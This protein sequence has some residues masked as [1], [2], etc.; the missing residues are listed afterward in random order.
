MSQSGMIFR[1][2]AGKALPTA[3]LELVIKNNPRAWG[4]CFVDDDGVPQ[5][6][7]GENPTVDLIEATV[8]EYPDKDLTFY[9]GNT[10]G[11]LNLDDVSPHVVLGTSDAP[12]IVG[13]VSGDFNSY[14][15]KESS[16][17]SEFFFTHEYLIP[18]L[19][20]LLE[21]MED[22]GKVWA[23]L[24]KPIMKKKM[25][26]EAT[27]SATI[28]LVAGNG[29]ALTFHQ[30][31]DS[32][33]YEWG[34][35]S[36]NYGYALAPKEEVSDKPKGMFS[37]PSTKPTSRSTVR[38]PA[39]QATTSQSAA[40]TST[41]PTAKATGGEALQNYSV[42]KET[43]PGHLSRKDKK[44][45]IK[46]RIG[47][48]PKG[49]D[50]KGFSFEVYVGP[51]GKTLMHS[52]VKTLGLKAMGLP[53][54]NNPEWEKDETPDTVQPEHAKP[55]ETTPG[56]VTT[57]LLPILSPA[58]REYF[59]KYKDSDAVKKQIAENGEAVQDPKAIQALEEK[60]SSFPVQLGLKSWAD[61]PKFTHAHRFEIAKTRPDIAAAA[62]THLTNLCEKSG[63]FK[64]NTV[65]EQQKQELAAE[66][67]K[68]EVKG[69]FGK[70]STKPKRSAA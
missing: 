3:F 5:I 31:D 35:T 42:R 44:G 16:H 7:K 69:M 23:H 27:S 59:H 38:E 26:L 30:G 6:A 24:N 61:V 58:A 15:K 19:Q 64:D 46:A 56:Q 51:D 68:P 29:E 50:Q 49:W 63:L 9:V 18:E 66:E 47:Y 8:E 36:H 41:K 33:E 55:A 20:A 70:P 25:L 57:D 22:P 54:L 13:F 45:Y 62:W 4:C 14:A 32:A 43:I 40:P 67:L 2:S 28:T 34:W 52:Q 37:K 65:S 53:K 11:A 12:G 39:P 60:I 17:P 21:G 1:R 10:D 48:T